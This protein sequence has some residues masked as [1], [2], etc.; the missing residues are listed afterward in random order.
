MQCIYLL[1]KIFL[2]GEVSI[3]KGPSNAVVSAGELATFSCTLNVTR[4]EMLQFEVFGTK[5][6]DSLSEC[7]IDM[8]TYSRTL[9]SWPSDGISMTCDYNVPYQITCNLTLSGL[10]KANSTRVTCSSEAGEAT[11][12]TAALAV[13]SE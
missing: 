5:L 4:N 9:C 10:T 2:L 3:E 6:N 12:S 1:P 7:E 11:L 8:S 13:R